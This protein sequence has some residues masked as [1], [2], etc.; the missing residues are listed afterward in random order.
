M[1]REPAKKGNARVERMVRQKRTP[2]ALALR[3]VLAALLYDLPNVYC[4]EMH[5]RKRDR[6]SYDEECPVVRR[7]KKAVEDAKKLLA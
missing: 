4:V 3:R 7:F 2:E 1:K 6:H 5:H